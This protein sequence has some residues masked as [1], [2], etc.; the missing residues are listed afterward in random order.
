[1]LSFYTNFSY[2]S[3]L[4]K[5]KISITHFHFNLH[6]KNTIYVYIK[7]VLTVI[8]FMNYIKE[9]MIEQKKMLPNNLF[10]CLHYKWGQMF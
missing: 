4:N 6:P 8:Q 10:F 1:M 3:I 2:C 5:N 9:K 7:D